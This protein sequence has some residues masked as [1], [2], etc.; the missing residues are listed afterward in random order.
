MKTILHIQNTGIENLPLKN[1]F[2]E[3]LKSFLDIAINLIIDGQPPEVFRLILDSEYDIILNHERINMETILCLQLIKEVSW[4]IHCDK[5]C[6]GYLLS[7]TN[8]WGNNASE[9]AS[10]TFYP[11]LPKEIKERYHI[12]DLIKYMPQDAFQLDDY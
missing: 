8:L 3:P 10:K 6:Y 5:D 4:H 1:D 7:T 12:S 9:Y 2:K 11:N